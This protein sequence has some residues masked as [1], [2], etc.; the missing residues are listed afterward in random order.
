MIH[1]CIGRSSVA[2]PSSR[3]GPCRVEQADGVRGKGPPAIGGR[4][5]PHGLRGGG[6]SGGHQVRLP[7]RYAQMHG[8]EDWVDRWIG[9]EAVQRVCINALEYES[10]IELVS[11]PRAPAGG[12]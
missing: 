9:C 6:C 7:S 4:P 5:G 12:Q 2:S 3:L 11:C 8:H 1:L 10:A